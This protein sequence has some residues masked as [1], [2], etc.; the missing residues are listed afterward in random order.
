VSACGPDLTKAA[1]TGWTNGGASSTRAITSG[2]S[3]SVEF[4]LPAAPGYVMFGLGNDDAAADYADIDYAFYTY[5]PTG[6]V[7]VYENGT[8]RGTF[9]AYAAGDRLRIAV[10][11]GTVTYL[12]NDVTV[13]TS[14]TGASGA[15]RV[16]TSL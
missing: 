13:Y 3:G 1:P 4:T 7:M 11:G 14:G 12:S 10:S 2:G 5:P 8:C 9:G 16:D 6:Q 15:L